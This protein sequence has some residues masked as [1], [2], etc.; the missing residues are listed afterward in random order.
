MLAKQTLSLVHIEALKF[1]PDEFANMVR[2]DVEEHGTKIVMID[3]ISG[4]R[5]SVSGHELTE[6]LHALCRYLQNVGVTVLL[7]NE[8]LEHLRVSRQRDRH[9]LPRGQRRLP[10]YVEQRV[11]GQVEMGRVVG[12]LKK[13]LSDFEKSPRPFALTPAG[14]TIGAPSPD[15]GAIAG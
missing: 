4:Y 15:L 14:V 13:R 10:R 3:S 5:L 8:L 11:D 2:R 9:Q 1:S 12:V 6:R 7:V